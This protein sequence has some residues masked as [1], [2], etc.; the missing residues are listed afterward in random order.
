MNI[1]QY[2]NNLT[3]Q[4]FEELCTEYLK[5]H[6]KNKNINIHGTRLKK[7]G[8]KDIVGTACDVPYEIWAEC[9]RHNRALG[10]EKISKN[11][12]LVISKGINELIYFSTSDITRTA[13][14]HVSIVAAKHNFSVT[15]IYGKRL[16]Q[17][18]SIL[19]RF[20]Y[21]FEKPDKIIKNDLKISRFFS[22]FEDTEQY[23]EGSELI[24]QRDNIFY[25]DI[26]L[27]NL[28]NTT[29]SDVTCILPKMSDI[30]FHLPEIHN[31]FN[32]LQ[33]SNRVIQIR[34]E[35]L[36]SYTRKRIPPF[37][38]KYKCNNHTYS[39]K[40]PGG[41]ID[42]TKLIYYPLIGENVQNFLSNKILPLVKDKIAS[43][44]YM[45]N[46]TGK[47]GT[48]KTRLLSEIINLAKSYNFQTLYCDARK[49]TG[50]AILREYLC[51]CL[52]LPYGTG[53]ISCTLD[54]FSKI[55]EQYY[56]NHKVSDAVFSF[57]FHE[58]IDADILYYL[59]EALLFFSCNIVGGTPLIWTIDNLQC[60]D[61]ETL[62]IIYFLVEHLQK[63]FPE[64][65]F[66]LGTNTEIVPIENQGFVNE[67]LT[68][69]N[70]YGDVV[71][72]V[73]NCDEMQNN[74]AKT[75]YYHAIPNLQG[76]DYF[77]HLLLNKSGKRPFDIIML[78]HWFYDQNLINTSTHN[79]M[80]PSAKE[81][82]KNFINQIP[83]KSK[84]IITQR[85]ELQKH[86]N[87]SVHTSLTYF[88]AFK[89]V[90]KSILYF[91]GETPVDFLLSL[92]IDENMLFELSQSLFFKYM[93]KYPKIV[94]YHDNIYRYFETY[95]FYQN[96]RVLSLQIIKWL[97]ENTWYKSNLRATA[98]FDCYIRA[99][100]FEE[101]VKFGMSSISSEY[102]KRNFQAIIH[103]GTELLKDIPENQSTLAEPTDNP[104][105]EF[106]DASTKFRIYYAVADAYRI[107]QDLSQSVYYY[108][109]AYQILQQYSISGFNS[110]DTCKFF[111]R[112]SNACISAADYDD[113]LAVLDYF[114]NY[115]E[116]NK[117]YDFI[118]HNRYSVVYLAINDIEN[119]LLS[120]DESLEIAKECKEPQWES[121]S[122][123]DKAYI[124]YR[125]YEDKENTI[126]Y[127]SKAV[128][129]HISEKASIN[130][131]SEILA[132]E[133][134]VNLL[135]DNLE[136]AER[137]ADL[138]LNRALEINGTS[139][140]VKS[141]NLLGIIQ[142]FNN[143]KET[144]FSTW[145][146][147]LIISAQ[148]MNKDGL[149]KLHT[150][151]GAAYILQS[152]YPLAREELEQAYTLY[153]KFKVSP[154][155]HK[156]LIYNLLLIYNILGDT[157][158][159]DK[160]F[161]EA[162]FDNLY[163]YYNQLISNNH[164]IITEYYWPLQFGHIFFNY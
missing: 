163:S 159:R 134:F 150:N 21:D 3:D 111:H 120:I 151:L 99:F 125:A 128:E 5:L 70:E 49:Q 88:D 81:E 118:L 119:A 92:K 53:N 93:D 105:T 59:R 66:S 127:F 87:F 69:I 145:K 19:P 41:S 9:K 17:E 42:P 71:S 27:T 4:E 25:I 12:I 1:Q 117:F 15:F 152:E 82:I 50:F 58:K 28:Y 34:A 110:I 101:A 10:L 137:M 144:A 14:K 61:K 48:G 112:Y 108:K 24:L 109:K 85:F 155:T 51:A 104:F 20:Q 83:V 121:I 131:S 80:I 138:A 161:E 6:Y 39:K 32:M 132:Q 102:D 146:K 126:L 139:M 153:Q 149:V 46:I 63:R 91:G 129:K 31:H 136:E 36:N 52:G 133:A 154:M 100:E 94:F 116:R 60:L 47:S 114:K 95:K 55:I 89:S 78:I 2:I 75:L 37:I 140:E 30:I 65:I 72:L 33:G 26:Y 130:R 135:T 18:L 22:V 106:M 73:Y 23:T 77:T 38:L 44:I 162:C 86:K 43:Q 164:N 122:Y 13:I 157:S 148:R 54:D 142:Y 107:Y 90:V 143:K 45:L 29:V 158:K 8:G 113:A 57:V 68:K 103:I 96:D 16:Y 76:F 64:V 160:L 35:V 7:D 123:S 147:D 11:V 156:P 79:M 74:D 56:G 98:I 67:F 84:E 115:K 40:I 124:Y 141:R 62:D 97:N